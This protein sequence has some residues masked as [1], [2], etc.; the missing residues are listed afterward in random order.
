MDLHHWPAENSALTRRTLK[1]Y[2]RSFF[3]SAAADD[4]GVVWIAVD[5]AIAQ[6]Q[7]VVELAAAIDIVAWLGR[8]VEAARLGQETRSGAFA[9]AAV[10]AAAAAAVVAA[11]AVAVAAAAVVAVAAAAAA[12]G[13]FAGASIHPSA[14]H[15]SWLLYFIPLRIPLAKGRRR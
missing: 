3:H 15:P 10:A 13:C 9:V 11:A 6:W 4:A 2:S 8:E 1:N 12:G 14:F 7:Q 5:D